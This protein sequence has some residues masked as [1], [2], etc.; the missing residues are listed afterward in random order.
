MPHDRASRRRRLAELAVELCDVTPA[1]PVGL[2][3]EHLAAWLRGAPC[4]GSF[5]RTRAWAA[6]RAAAEPARANEVKAWAV[7]EGASC[8]CEL[9][10]RLEQP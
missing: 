5:G 4:D 9:A 10:A 1:R 3:R 7:A 6:R 2:E 8:D